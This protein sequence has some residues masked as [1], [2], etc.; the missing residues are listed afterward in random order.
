MHTISAARDFKKIFP[1]A[2]S[3]DVGDSVSF[4]CQSDDIKWYFE[5]LKYFPT[6]T[7]ISTYKNYHIRQVTN[8]NSGNYFCYGKYPDNSKHFLA[9][10]T[11]T[12]Y[13]KTY[14][15]GI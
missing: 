15:P 3:A 5:K 11:L 7:P 10:A 8:V 13:G 9:K 14:R 12:V 1:A 4:T 6:S 2:N